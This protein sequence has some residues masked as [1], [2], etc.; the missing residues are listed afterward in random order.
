[1]FILHYLKWF[2]EQQLPDD[3]SDYKIQFL[4]AMK[5]HGNIFV[6]YFL[7]LNALHCTSKFKFQQERKQ[8]ILHVKSC[9]FGLN[10]EKHFL[11]PVLNNNCK[12]QDQEN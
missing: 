6:K 8:V 11:K 2:Q 7:I 9:G 5:F 1:M 12:I 4:F 10:L 3:E